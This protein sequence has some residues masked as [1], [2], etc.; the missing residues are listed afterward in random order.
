MAKWALGYER[1]LIMSVGGESIGGEGRSLCQYNGRSLRLVLSGI[2]SHTSQCL[3]EGVASCLQEIAKR[4]SRQDAIRL[5]SIEADQGAPVE[6][7]IRIHGGVQLVPLWEE[8]LNRPLRTSARLLAR[9]RRPSRLALQRA[10][11]AR[12]ARLQSSPSS[13]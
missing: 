6:D 10:R 8:A 12:R 2:N 13:T 3:T 7:V 11:H 4:G 1:L 5:S 9:R